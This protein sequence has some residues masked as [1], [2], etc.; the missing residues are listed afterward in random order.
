VVRC[1]ATTCAKGSS[2]PRGR[3]G[4]SA[5]EWDCIYRELCSS[6]TRGRFAHGEGIGRSRGVR[7]A[8]A[9]RRTG[10]PPPT[11]VPR[12]AARSGLASGP[13]PDWGRVWRRA[14]REGAPF[15]A[16]TSARAWRRTV[17]SGPSASGAR[18]S[19]CWP[20]AWKVERWDARIA[21]TCSD[22]L[23][24]QAWKSTG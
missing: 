12:C 19:S 2:G 24:R 21:I 23:D 10:V 22:A 1:R 18:A 9:R 16:P 7:L 17:R 4:G 8:D 3:G 6:P 5:P 15:N 20:A 11:N 13:H 14:V